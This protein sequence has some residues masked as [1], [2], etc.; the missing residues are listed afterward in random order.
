M[1]KRF[2]LTLILLAEMAFPGAVLRAG[3]KPEARM[4]IIRGLTAEYASLKVP[5]PRGKKGLLLGSDGKIDEQSLKHEITQYGTAAAPNTLVQL[6]AID[7]E[8]KAIIV[9][10]NGGGKSKSHW[11]QHVEVGMGNTTRP[12]S[13]ENQT[14]TG[15]S[16]TL[17]FAQKLDELTV[18]QI[19][20]YLSPVLNF[21]PVNIL[22]APSRPVPPEFE[23]AIKEKKAAVGMDRELVIAAMGQP[24]R[25]V[26]EEKEGVEQEDWIYGTPPMKVTFVTFE[27]EEV[28]NVQD[29]I[30]GI[31]GEMQTSPPA[32]PR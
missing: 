21:N 3:L 26:R 29:Y 15:S 4:E 9:E 11:Y 27:G 13:Q 22:Q 23:Q 28:V 20:E 30:G 31:R 16:I 14:P 32:D 17:A 10:I 18:A 7:I 24:Q 1:L 19:K 8:N 5:L 25:K 2:H 6:T 12:I